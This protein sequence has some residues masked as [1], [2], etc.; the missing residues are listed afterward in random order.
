MTLLL[1]GQPDVDAGRPVQGVVDGA[2]RGHREQG[3]QPFGGHLARHVDAHIDALH[4]GRPAGAHRIRDLDG[5]PVLGQMVAREV[6]VGVETHTPGQAG[7]E[8]LGGRGPGVLTTVRG[9][10]IHHYLVTA[11]PQ[12][13]PVAFDVVSGDDV[14]S[15]HTYDVRKL[16]GQRTR[17]SDPRCG[18]FAPNL[19]HLTQGSWGVR[20]L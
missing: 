9:G 10:L 8:D 20:S 11:H 6:A 14:R 4:P 3:R 18:T 13:E 7:H 15:V 5:E 1:H 12:D 2:R 17:A 16:A 19:A